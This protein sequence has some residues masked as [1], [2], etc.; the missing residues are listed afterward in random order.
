[1]KNDDSAHASTQVDF[2]VEIES[3]QEQHGLVV[4]AQ[5]AMPDG[6]RLIIETANAAMEDNIAIQLSSCQCGSCVLLSVSDTGH[7][8]DAE[9]QSRIFKPFFTTKEHG[10]GL[11]L[12]IVDRILKENSGTVS[13]QSEIKHGTTFKIYL[14]QV[15]DDCARGRAV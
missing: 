13:F 6:E 2:P 5:Q 14:P 9:T 7:G 10:T 15:S 8:M 4:N 11:G 1:M 12:S 3:Q